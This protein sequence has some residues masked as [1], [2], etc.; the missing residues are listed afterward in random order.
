MEYHHVVACKTLLDLLQT[1][2]MSARYTLNAQGIRP[3][4]ETNVKTP[5]PVPVAS[6][7]YAMCLITILFAPASMD[8]SVILSQAVTQ[9]HHQRE[10]RHRTLVIHPHVVRM[11][12][13]TT[14][15]AHA[16]QNITATHTPAV[17][18]NVS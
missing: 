2:V 8:T 12:N 14:E 6:T 5:A 7:Q 11:P 10:I 4:F 13:A 18:L 9:L 15:Y 16:F 3:A 17:V 1:A